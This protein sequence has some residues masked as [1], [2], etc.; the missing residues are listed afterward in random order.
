[1]LEL[2]GFVCFDLFE[3]PTPVSSVSLAILGY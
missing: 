3:E 1:M 2:V